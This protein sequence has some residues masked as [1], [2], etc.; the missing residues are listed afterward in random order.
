[1]SNKVPV[2]V[3]LAGGGQGDEFIQPVKTDEPKSLL[4]VSLMTVLPIVIL[5][6][7]DKHFSKAPLKSF[8]SSF[9]K[10]FI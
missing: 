6:G 5:P 7:V 10:I 2:L 8:N 9:F 4:A 1:M 3:L